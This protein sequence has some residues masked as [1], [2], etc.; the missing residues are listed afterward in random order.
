MIHIEKRSARFGAALL[1]FALL[2]RLVMTGVPALVRASSSE[3]TTAFSPHR[4]NGGV[5]L[6]VTTPE[7]TVPVA[8]TSPSLPTTILPTAPTIPAPPPRPPAITFSQTDMTYVNLQYGS[9]CGYRADAQALLL[10]SIDWQLDS[11]EPAVL[12]VH[13]HATESYT[14]QNG[15]TYQ[16]SSAYR[17]SDTAYNMVAVGDFL[18][19]QLQALGIGVI[20]DRQLHDEPSYNAAYSSSRKSVAAYL[21]EYPSIRIVLDLH[22]DAALNADGSQYATSAT[23]NGEKAAQIMLL[24][25]TD[26][27][28]GSHPQWEENLSLALKLQVLL[29]QAHPGI[30]RRTLLRGSVFNQDLCSGML[31]VEVGTA[32][33]TLTHALRTMTPLANAIAALANG[34]NIT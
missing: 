31:I 9:D 4:P 11:G 17:T 18:A 34:A 25:G 23:V 32:G 21:E 29:E 26:W 20:H 33:N 2:L 22:R 14:R 6:S 1:I 5:S 27:L 13:S 3:E 16:E 15:D 8:T 24:A 10:G 28:G 7:T 12:I 30:T 19:A